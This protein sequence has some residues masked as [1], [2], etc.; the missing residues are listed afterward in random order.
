MNFKSNKA[1]RIYYSKGLL[2]EYEIH[3]KKI[4]N[5]TL[6]GFIELS[7]FVYP[8]KKNIII[9]PGSDR[10]EKEFKDVKRTYIPI[11]DVIRIDEYELSSETEESHLKVIE[12][13]KQEKK[14]GG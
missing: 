13:K 8:Q 4:E 6:F 9:E 2:Q 14:Q 12:F 1:F 11:K 10:I 3:A 7:E 5:S